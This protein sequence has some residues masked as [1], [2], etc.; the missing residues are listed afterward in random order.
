MAPTESMLQQHTELG[1]IIVELKRP[2]FHTST[3]LAEAKRE[4]LLDK[5]SA[6]STRIAEV[7]ICIISERLPD[8][9]RQLPHAWETQVVEDDVHSVIAQ[10]IEDVLLMVVHHDNAIS[11]CRGNHSSRA[12]SFSQVDSNET[13][14]TLANRHDDRGVRGPGSA[15]FLLTLQAGPSND[16]DRASLL[17]RQ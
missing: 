7:T 4:R 10:G 3:N 2:V 9:P 15:R 17:Q 1:A 16:R 12:E 8:R 14:A 5:V 13:R 6:T 11:R